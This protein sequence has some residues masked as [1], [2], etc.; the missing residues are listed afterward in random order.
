MHY[1]K[2]L[3]RSF[4]GGLWEPSSSRNTFLVGRSCSVP[5]DP[6]L[7]ARARFQLQGGESQFSPTYLVVQAFLFPSIGVSELKP[8]PDELPIWGSHSLR[9]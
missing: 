5:G 4:S 6:V 8:S 7:K 9:T 1:Y 2:G 3:S